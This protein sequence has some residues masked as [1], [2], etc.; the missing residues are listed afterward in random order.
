MKTNS[1]EHLLL[2]ITGITSVIFFTAVFTIAQT[3]QTSHEIIITPPSL[4]SVQIN[5]NGNNDIQLTAAIPQNAGEALS[6]ENTNDTS[7]WLNYSVISEQGKDIY[8]S[9]ANGQVPTGFALQV[10][11]TTSANT[12]EGNL[13]HSEGTVQLTQ[14]DQRIINGITSCYT[15][16]GINNGRQLSYSLV[17]VGEY[18]SVESTENTT[19]TVCYTIMD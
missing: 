5:G 14:Q 16:E 18:A 12:G 6:F 19:V 17:S 9:I 13:G 7:L 3:N 15:G 2:R 10:N 4:S 8:V 11:A 1:I